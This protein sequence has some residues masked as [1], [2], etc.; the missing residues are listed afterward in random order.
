MKATNVIVQEK[1]DDNVT[2]ISA[3]PSP[4]SGNNIWTI[5]EID[6][7]DF[8]EININVKVPKSVEENTVVHNYVSVTCDQNSSDKVEIDTYV[9]SFPPETRKQ[10]DGEVIN[11]TLLD[12]D[13]D[14][15]IM[16]YIPQ[17]TVINLVATDNGSGINVTY[18]RIFK[19]IGYWQLL[20]NWQK[21]GI[22]KSY[23]PY[24]PINLSALASLYNFSSC[25]KYEIEFY[26][27]DNAGNVEGIKWNDVFVDC[28]SPVSEIEKII[29]Y[30]IEETSININVIAYDVGV[31][32]KKIRLYYR[33]SEDNSSWGN[34]TLY[35]EKK[36]NFSWQFNIS[37]YGYYEFYSV[38]YDLFENHE[39]LPNASSTPKARCKISQPSWDINM[40]G[41]VNIN[42]ILFIIMYWGKQEGDEGWNPKADVNNDGIVNVSDLTEIVM[43][44]TG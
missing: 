16:H 40:D 24:Y 18:Y 14:A 41:K 28:A 21:Y 31:G 6:V 35:G 22:W 9:V 5:E 38:A 33:Y 3:S 29:P 15:Y 23:P 37:N 26:S 19:W 13:S 7:N 1:Y 4:T 43:H 12:G 39:S 17:D 27:V 10:F 34:W 42:D 36:S 30:K 2:F 25:G 11:V 20:F 44:W 8:Y 32:I